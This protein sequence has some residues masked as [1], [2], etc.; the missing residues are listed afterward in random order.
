MI[1]AIDIGNT[2]TVLGI[3]KGNKLLREWRITSSSYRREGQL[4]KRVQSFLRWNSISTTMITGVVIASVV[5]RLT[6]IIKRV[7]KKYLKLRPLIVAST[8]DVGID[9]LYKNPKG[10]GADRVCNV[11]AAFEKY[12]GPTIAVD[13]GTATTYDVVSKNG[14]YLGGI[15]APSVGISARELY[16]RTAQLPMIELSFPKN[17]LGRSS[18]ECMRSGVLYGHI[19]SFEGLIKRIRKITGK[20]TKVVATGGYAKMIVKRSRI[21]TRLEPSLVLEGARLI[22]ERNTTTRIIMKRTG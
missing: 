11:V 8:L 5:P 14:Q 20:H 22:Y 15:I 3:F 10:L 4:L 16:H 17:V 13:F 6:T 9:I 1:L 19:E 18:V 21:R 2:D 7:I 12:G